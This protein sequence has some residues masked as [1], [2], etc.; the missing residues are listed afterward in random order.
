MGTFFRTHV[1]IKF[2]QKYRF[3]IKHI[4]TSMEFHRFAG[5]VQFWF[6]VELNWSELKWIDQ[7][8]SVAAVVLG[9]EEEI[10]VAV[11]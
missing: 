2:V 10:W 1:Y 6:F 7:A 4:H 3:Y 5:T 11:F 8:I 9:G